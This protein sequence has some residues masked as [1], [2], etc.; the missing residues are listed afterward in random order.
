MSDMAAQT[1][2]QRRN[3][4]YY[5]RA[6][7]PVDL[8][9]YFGRKEEK[10]SLKTSDYREARHRAH[11]A[12]AEFVNKCE[13]LRRGIRRPG[14]E[15][16]TVIL[17][18]EAITQV[19]ALWRYLT[20]DGD[21]KTRQEGLSAAEFADLA[22]ARAE[23]QEHLKQILACGQADQIL[24]ALNQ[25]LYLLGVD[26]T[27]NSE[28]W[29]RLQYKFLQTV[30]EAHN[31]QIQ[32]DAGEVVWTPPAPTHAGLQ[33]ASLTTT[34]LQMLVEDWI[35]FQPN[36]PQK[37]IDDVKR[38]IGE[39]QKIIG[40]KPAE[41]ITRQDL[42]TFRDYL[43]QDRQHKAKT[44][45]KKITFLSTVFNVAIHNGKMSVNPASRMPLPKDDSDPRL[46]YD[47]DD[48]KAI[49]GSPLYTRG[50]RLGRDTCEAGVW[51]PLLS[52]YQGAREEELGQLLTEDVVK[53]DGI[54]C[55]LITNVNDTRKRLKNRAS[56]RRLPLHPKVIEA[57]FVRY[58]NK[59]AASGS[60]RI[61][62]SLTPDKYGKLTSDFSKAYMKYTRAELG[63]TDPNKVFHSLRHSFRDACREAD[64]GEELADALMGHSSRGKTGRHYGKSFSLSKLHE[65]ICRI[66]YP[67]LK[68]PVLVPDRGQN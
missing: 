63:I 27:G 48:L 54:W 43:V 1:H 51:L 65:A 40:R 55:L 21:E 44:V 19:C 39:F 23:T 8:Q 58:V 60:A 5:F 24:P 32:R 4:R 66:D 30:A 13:A 6:K 53:V 52:L 3:G 34:S 20:L 10:F 36:R 50:E 2:L 25:F 46:P 42:M 11:L 67:G 38:V 29:R 7:I 12:S 17:D 35:R 45:E 68:I 26:L 56:R 22:Q 15:P 18:D 28:A 33:P 16:Q 59:V 37:T 64:I 62:P 61:F 41:G 14:S 9:L 31:L 57:G 49:F 47:L